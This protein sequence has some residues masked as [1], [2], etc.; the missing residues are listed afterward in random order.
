MGVETKRQRRNLP[1][2]PMPCKQKTEMIEAYR[3][4]FEF[5]AF[6][7]SEIQSIC[8]T[9]SKEAYEHVKRL[10]EDARKECDMARERLEVHTRAH[11]C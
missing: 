4:A 6:S 8:A 9:A 3:K 2:T 1:T 10:S 7:V 5:Y 11:G